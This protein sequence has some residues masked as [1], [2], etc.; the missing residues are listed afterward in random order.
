MQDV[1]NFALDKNSKID[2]A[3]YINLKCF[4]IAVNGNDKHKAI[5]KVEKLLVK[6]W[7]SVKHSYFGTALDVDNYLLLK[8]KQIKV[9]K[10]YII[11]IPDVNNGTIIFH[12]L[13]VYLS[14][15]K[16]KKAKRCVISG[17]F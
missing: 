15:H 9:R 11:Q 7:K 3:N 13:G 12:I 17:E 1:I 14:K 8:Q 2:V 5:I 16:D 6:K 4:L 10:Y